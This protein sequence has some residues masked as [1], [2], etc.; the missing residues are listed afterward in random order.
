V[1]FKKPIAMLL[2]QL[3]NRE[4]AM[5]RIL[6]AVEL[7]KLKQSKSI[8]ALS[9]ALSSDPFWGVRIEASSALQNI[10]TDHALDALAA[11]LQQTDARVRLQ[12]VQDIS[13]F[14]TQRSRDLLLDLL[15]H[16]SNPSIVGAA[17]RG[18]GIRH[19]ELSA[20]QLREYLRSQSF[21]N[22]LVRAALDAINQNGGEKFIPDLL[23]LLQ[24]RERELETADVGFAL[25]T[26]ARL[27]SKT[28]HVPVVKDLLL[29]YVNSPRELI[30]ISAIL[31][32]GHLGDEGARGRLKTIAGSDRLDRV[33]AAARVA[34]DM[35]DRRSQSG[36][37]GL[38]E[39][40]EQFRKMKQEQAEL[41]EKLKLLQPEADQ[42]RE[43][44]ADDS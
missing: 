2:A 36:A 37:T 11:N 44:E 23:T 38:S 39:L 22:Q 27:S 10:Q 32:L 43:K 17:I 34:L 13:Q 29:S 5:G 7:G 9:K 16:E 26:L 19:D 41:K 4:D 24:I 42:S 15:K 1:Q 3:E 31:S 30:R 12:I 14:Y 20:A 6:A 21:H 40:R 35:L 33:A 28:T 8:A 25:E 18:L